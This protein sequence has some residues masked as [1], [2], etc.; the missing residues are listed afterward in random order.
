M[1]DRNMQRKG[2]GRAAVR[3]VIARFKEK[4]TFPDNR[5]SESRRTIYCAKAILPRKRA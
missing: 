5:S 4:P 3:D 2:Y 1:V